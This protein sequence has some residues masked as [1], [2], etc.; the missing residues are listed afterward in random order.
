MTKLKIWYI[1][2]PV[3]III[4]NSAPAFSQVGISQ[5][6]K[7]RLEEK[8]KALKTYYIDDDG[9]V[10][11]Y[12]NDNTS[13]NTPT[14]KSSV[15][16]VVTPPAPKPVSEVVVK[17]E[18]I[19]DTHTEDIG[20]IGNI[21]IIKDDAI[22]NSTQSS[23]NA[24]MFYHEEEIVEEE[25]LADTTNLVDET[26]II[27]E[28]DTVDN[29]TVD[30]IIYTVDTINDIDTVAIPEETEET[31]VFIEDETELAEQPDTDN[32]E[33]L[34]ADN[35]TV[36]KKRDVFKKYQ[37]SYSSLEEAA[38]AT[39]DLLEKLKLELEHSSVRKVVTERSSLSQ[40]LA[41]G[42]NSIMR[43]DYSDEIKNLGQQSSVSL[44]DLPGDNGEPTYFINGVQ[45]DRLEVDKLK[46][47]N[48]RKKQVK[49]ST[50][51]PNGEWWIETR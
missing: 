48:I 20:D 14:N 36:E 19:K 18:N 35:T 4:C 42:V 17:E 49:R 1:L 51:N 3:L 22:N 44:S 11:F 9:T 15:T 23:F 38:M 45:A 24:D 6:E 37:P 41:G 40:R 13:N 25:V 30:D 33:E 32:N 29:M 26:D 8:F 31:Q 47:E 5:Q 43:K 50:T 16:P 7:K 46:P 2:I 34:I 21:D 28:V 27:D 12:T 39:E 10:V